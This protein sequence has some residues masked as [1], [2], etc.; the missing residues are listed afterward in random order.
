MLS[1]S[2]SWTMKWLAKRVHSLLRCTCGSGERVRRPSESAYKKKYSDAFLRH[3]RGK[4]MHLEPFNTAGVALCGRTN[5]P[6][7]SIPT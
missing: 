3:K 2:N 4:K 5:S 1:I 7:V 6:E